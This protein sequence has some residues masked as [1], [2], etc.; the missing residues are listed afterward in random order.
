[1]SF[2]SVVLLAAGESKRMGKLKQ[3]LPVDGKPLV[4]FSLEKYLESICDEVV[5]VVGCEADKVSAGVE[6]LSGRH[7]TVFN[8]N[9]SQGMGTSISKGLEAVSDRASGIMIALADMPCISTKFINSLI[10]FWRGDISCIA[11]PYCGEKRGNPVIF[12]KS[13]FGEL[14][15]LN[16]VGGGFSVIEN[17]SRL[18]NRFEVKET[19]ICFDVDTPQDW[20][21]FNR[22][23]EV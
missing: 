13:L 21:L 10:Y 6:Q 4:K 5:L 22:V 15:L 12:P 1:M 14:A 7:V 3:L 2:L 23:R 20:T 11:V 16:G 19:D 8:A 9:Y 17:N 18:I